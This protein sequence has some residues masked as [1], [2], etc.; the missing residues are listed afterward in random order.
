MG[1]IAVQ[2][3]LVIW[4]VKYLLVRQLTTCTCGHLAAGGIR[5]DCSSPT[6]LSYK[7]PTASSSS[8]PQSSS[9]LFLSSFIITI[10]II[11]IYCCHSHHRNSIRIFTF[12]DN[13]LVDLLYHG[14]SK[15]YRQI[16]SLDQTVLFRFLA[17]MEGRETLSFKLSQ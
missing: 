5:W 12:D 13:I 2:Y 11:T 17:L 4:V 3:F 6:C 15:T 8:S 7:W 14:A 1:H 16:L 10:L 9:R